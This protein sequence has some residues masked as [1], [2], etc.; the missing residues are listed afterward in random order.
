MED[1]DADEGVVLN[2]IPA[3]NDPLADHYAQLQ[4]LEQ[5][6]ITRARQEFEQAS[7]RIRTEAALRI[8]ELEA[9]FKRTSAPRVPP[10]P[11]CLHEVR[12]QA[13]VRWLAGVDSPECWQLAGAV[14]TTATLDAM[15]CSSQH[16]TRQ[17]MSLLCRYGP[18]NVVPRD[19][20]RARLR[21]VR[22]NRR[23]IILCESC[24]F[25]LPVAELCIAD[26]LCLVDLSASERLHVEY[27]MLAPGRRDCDRLLP[28]SI[29]PG[30]SKT[31]SEQ[32][33]VL[34]DPNATTSAAENA[35][36][37]RY[38]I[39]IDPSATL[40]INCR[41]MGNDPARWRHS[42]HLGSGASCPWAIV[43]N[44]C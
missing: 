38:P 33:G 13:F 28:L 3:S 40:T 7:Q 17:C 42:A 22:V 2:T 25:C 19:P 39:S 20:E 32:H 5:D 36:N 14:G 35:T 27:Q 24:L 41:A 4:E 1:A 10:V 26:A 29:R 37:A 43:C 6:R 11:P 21:H 16:E 30:G 34:A 8:K 15:P 44:L 31:E 9:A 12:A 23:C 18:K